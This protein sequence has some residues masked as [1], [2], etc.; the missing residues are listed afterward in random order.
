MLVWVALLFALFSGIGFAEDIIQGQYCY[1]YGD[2][3]SLQEARELTR[4]LAI[5]NAIESYGVFIS[6]ASSVKNFT[7][8]NDLVQIISQG[9]L[10]DIKVISH[11]EEGRM[12]CDEIQA[13]ISPQAI[14]NIMKNIKGKVE[15]A[16]I[17]DLPSNPCIRVVNIRKSEEG[18]IEVVVKALLLINYEVQASLRIVHIDYYDSKG[19]P[20]GRDGRFI[21]EMT[22]GQIKSVTF[23]EPPEG[24]ASWRVWLANPK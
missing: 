11:K 19:N 17:P 20:I 14:E 15:E 21:V 3:E 9:Y 13:S 5:R 22:P 8:T 6:S 24:T 12:I 18:L 23:S 2:R 10:K 16:D 7:L 4:F 1:T